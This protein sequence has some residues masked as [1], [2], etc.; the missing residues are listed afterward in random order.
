MTFDEFELDSRLKQVLHGQNFETPTP[1][2][3]KGIPLAL[4]ERDVIMIAQTGTGKTLAYALPLLTKIAAGKPAKNMVL[5]LVPTRELVSQVNKVFVEFGHALRVRST[6][7]YGGVGMQPQIDGLRKGCAVVVATP[8][9][10]LDHMHRGNAKFPDL[11]TLVLDEADRMLDMGFLPDITDIVQRM[12]RERQT[13]MC[14]ATFPDEIERLAMRMLKDPERVIV[15]PVSKPVDQV[16]QLL[17]PVS[18]ENKLDVLLK[19]LNDHHMNSAVIFMRTKHRTDLVA[20]ALKR[21]GYEAAAIHGDR[22]Q[23]DREKALDGF[24]KGQYKILCATDVAA[25]GL[26]IEGISHVI[27]YDIPVTSDDYLHRI[28]RTARA[29]A[30]GDAMTLV[31]PDEH[32]ALFNIEKALGRHLPRE[33][34]DGAP[35]VLSTWSAPDSRVKSQPRHRRV[36]RGLF[37][38]R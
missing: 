25:R 19:I 33:E 12:P 27:N 32:E 36:A 37:R 8:G 9:R 17:Y 13:I 15:G 2:Q 28:G 38:R 22:S 23:K 30:E 21:A 29:L 24:R 14:S 6:A 1:I 11:M 7:I 31:C 18:H 16:R 10:L 3:E 4:S 34:Y 20:K 35:I 26:D 5:V